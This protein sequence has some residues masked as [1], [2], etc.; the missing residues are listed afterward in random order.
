MLGGRGG[1]TSISRAVHLGLVHCNHPQRQAGSSWDEVKM[2]YFHLRAA[3]EMP[4]AS[5][6]W[7]FSL[8]QAEQTQPATSV[9]GIGAG[10]LLWRS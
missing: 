4:R 6:L 5:C 7:S 8:T 9:L 10:E 3:A 1:P 2:R